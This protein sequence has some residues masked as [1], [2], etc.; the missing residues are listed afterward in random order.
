ME[1]KTEDHMIFLAVTILVIVACFIILLFLIFIKRKNALIKSKLDAEQNYKQE[2]VKTQI[3]IREET[4]RNISWE[5]HDNIGQLMTLAKIKT[6]NA[7][8]DSVE[9]EEASETIAKALTEL[10]ALSKSINPETIKNLNLVNALKTELLR[11]NRLNFL[12]TH[13]DIEGTSKELDANTNTILFRIL[14]EFFSNTIKH[15]QASNLWVN[16]E[17][18]DNRLIICAKDDGNGFHTIELN[19]G[20]GLTNMKT[21]AQLLGAEFFLDSQPNIGTTLRINLPT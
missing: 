18:Y 7:K 10:R 15:S 13:L 14:Q 19:D 6:Q 5:L 17:F 8:G 1:Y 9:L 20:Q 11:F 2:L 16:L 3:E 4:L 12:T 21:R